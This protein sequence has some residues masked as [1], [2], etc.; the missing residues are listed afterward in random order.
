MT[1]APDS[2][3]QKSGQGRQGRPCP[4]LAWSYFSARK[5]PEFL[6][7]AHSPYRVLIGSNCF[8]EFYKPKE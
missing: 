5:C 6:H 3:K 1:G 4:F 7:L 8:F 2:R